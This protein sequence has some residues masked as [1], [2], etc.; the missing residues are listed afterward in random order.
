MRRKDHWSPL[1]IFKRQR[2]SLEPLK[3]Q[4]SPSAASTYEKL[5]RRRDE[6]I[7]R[8]QKTIGYL[9]KRNFQAENLK[10]YK[11]ERRAAYDSQVYESYI[12]CSAPDF[13]VF[14]YVSKDQLIIHFIDVY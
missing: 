6:R 9:E 14:W 4:F 5:E 1:N 11:C 7:K 10:I 12:S 2:E 13:S 3:V 8:I